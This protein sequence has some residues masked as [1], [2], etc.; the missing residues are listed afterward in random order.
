MV[1]DSETLN[2]TAWEKRGDCNVVG[3]PEWTR[4]TSI[5]KSRGIDDAVL[6]QKDEI[7]VVSSSLKLLTT[8]QNPESL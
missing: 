2:H 6:E 4:Q 5:Q 3:Q 8:N 7:G 1:R